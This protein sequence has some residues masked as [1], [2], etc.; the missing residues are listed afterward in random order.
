MNAE[1]P[2]PLCGPVPDGLMRV[3]FDIPR[4]LFDE[5]RL[6]CLR[7]GMPLDRMIIAALCLA[8]VAP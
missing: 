5:L 4:E 7:R 1:H 3:T 2:T 6:A 8:A